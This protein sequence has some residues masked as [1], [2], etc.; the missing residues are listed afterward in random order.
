MN[1]IPALSA[2]VFDLDGTLIDQQAAAD[3]AST[4]WAAEHGITD[5]DVATRWKR[6]ATKHYRRWQAREISFQDQRRERVREFLNR[7]M[8][9]A[10]ASLVFD[11]YLDRY[12]TGWRLFDDAI[13]ALRRARDA[14]L[15]VAVLT[16]GDRAQQL[17]KIE[18]FALDGEIDLLL[19]SSDLPAGKPDPRAFAAVL[20]RLGAVAAEA[21]MI[22]DSREADYDGA[23]SFGMHAVH[24]DR[25]APPRDL[26]ADSIRTL[27]ELR[28]SSRRGRHTGHAQPSHAGLITD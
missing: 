12:E 15:A 26:V 11:G 5:G 6:I 21:I 25:E 22:G 1:R 14:G 27:D 20:E 8:T 2:V 9:D 19:C 4:A 13:P 10:E 23:R 7:P 24:L 3:A 28:F 17:R 16:N 18:R